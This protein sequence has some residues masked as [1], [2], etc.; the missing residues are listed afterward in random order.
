MIGEGRRHRGIGCLY[1]HD[2]S[3]TIIADN[4]VLSMNGKKAGDV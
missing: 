2:G 1:N 4:Q 3:H